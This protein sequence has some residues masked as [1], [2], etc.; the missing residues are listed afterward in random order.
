MVKN[1]ELP[2]TLIF[3]GSLT[4][5][6]YL[7]LP[8]LPVAP[9]V[10]S[11]HSHIY[12]LTYSFLI[13]TTFMLVYRSWI[14]V[15]PL[16]PLQAHSL[17]LPSTTSLLIY[18]SWHCSLTHSLFLPFS[19]STISRDFRFCHILHILP[20]PMF[21]HCSWFKFFLVPHFHYFMLFYRS[22]L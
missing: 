11:Y 1:T 20:S 10:K 9:E 5:S 4:H 3:S 8:C 21:I 7:P 16:I 18:R 15:L 22:W 13:T 19:C 14:L 2:V 17:L 6:L 12:R